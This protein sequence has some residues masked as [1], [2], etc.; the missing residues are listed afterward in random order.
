MTAHSPLFQNDVKCYQPVPNSSST[1]KGTV[2][3]RTYKL[4]CEVCERFQYQETKQY[5]TSSKCPMCG[6]DVVVRGVDWS[7]RLDEIRGTPGRELALVE[8]FGLAAFGFGT[9]L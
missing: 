3:L 2:F 4:E 9:G 6:A 7:G 8:A 5:E 1:V